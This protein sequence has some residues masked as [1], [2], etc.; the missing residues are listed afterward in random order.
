MSFETIHVGDLEYLRA[1]GLPAPHGFS[2]RYGGVSTGARATLDLGPGRGEAL[3]NVRENWRRF[4]AAVGFDPARLVFT[5]QIHG[6]AVRVVTAADCGEGLERPAPDCDGLATNVPG[7]ALA[8]FSADCAPVLLCDPVKGA[9][10]AVHAGWRGT[11]LGIAERAVETLVSVFGSD[12]ADIHAAIGPCIDRCCFETRADVP[13]AM[14][15]ALGQDAETTIDEHADGSFHVDLKDLNAIWLRR[16]GVTDISICPFCTSC[17]PE[18]F[19]SH[20][21]VGNE[22]GSLAAVLVCPEGAG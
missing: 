13:E 8:V 7:L 14:R 9:A 17:Q 5:H 22:R 6:D 12:P 15:A 3:E 10:A 2:T 4:G 19:W 21:R 18:R 1:T 20:R 11:A 16:A